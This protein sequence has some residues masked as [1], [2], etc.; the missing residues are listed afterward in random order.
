VGENTLP[1]LL[2][3]DDDTSVLTALERVLRGDFLIIKASDPVEALKFVKEKKP[4][5]LL[6][7]F[8]MPQMSGEEFLKSCRDLSPQT[9]RAVISGHVD[10]K[11]MEAL[12]NQN[13][14]HRFFMKPW[15]NDVLRMQMLECLSHHQL[16]MERDLL[17]KLAVTDPVTHLHNHRYFQD[18]IR[19]EVERSKRH[20]R[21]LSIIMADID[22]FKKYNDQN[23]H[24]QGDQLLKSAAKVFIS[25]LRNL[26]SVCR[27]G[28]DEFAMILPDTSVHDTFEVAER[29]RKSF[30][31][32]SLGGLTLSLGIAGFPQ[33][34]STAQD[35]I[36]AADK[37]LYEAK[38]KGRNQSVIAH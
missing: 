35:L 13:L 30:N 21:K 15:E 31:S 5:I 14:I 18:T 11:E 32:Q 28:G 27:Y 20:N 23:G 12:I 26:D 24:P 33:H 6:T 34:A 25:G 1:Y 2:L 37:A 4:A 36:A 7:D 38:N 29:L 9:I 16:L 10:L 22:G 3:V 17:E 8:S 19:I